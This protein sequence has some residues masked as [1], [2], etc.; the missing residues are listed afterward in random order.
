[1]AVRRLLL[2]RHGETEGESSVRFHGSSDVALSERGRAQMRGVAASLHGQQTLWVA[3]TLRRSWSAAALICGGAPL[4][5]EAELCEIHF[6][7]WEGLTR[8]EIQARDPHLYE[9][10][11]SGAEGFEFPGGEVR[12]DFQTRVAAATNRLLEADAQCIAAVLHKGVI[13]EIAMQLTGEPLANGAP[14]LAALVTLTR[15]GDTWFQGQ[16]SSN[17]T[18]LEDAA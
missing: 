13:R 4:R 9:E 10:W 17:P 18:N 14:G 2:V 3:S 11:Q 1:M 8:E 6:G 16:R 12:A 15:I 5:L 7:S